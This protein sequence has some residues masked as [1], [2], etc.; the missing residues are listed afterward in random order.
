MAFML[1]LWG[2]CPFNKGFISKNGQLK[3]FMACGYKVSS[4]KEH[5]VKPLLKGRAF[6]SRPAG[7]P[8]CA[9]LGHFPSN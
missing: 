6:V 8:T 1:C 4:G 3:L 7:Y 2:G 5:S 9:F